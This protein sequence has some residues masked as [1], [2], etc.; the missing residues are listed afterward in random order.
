MPVRLLSSSMI[1]MRSGIA[2]RRVTS[3]CERFR[4]AVYRSPGIPGNRLPLPLPERGNRRY[5]SPAK[6]LRQ[7]RELP[8]LLG[9]Q[10]IGRVGNRVEQSLRCRIRELELGLPYLLQRFAVHARLLERL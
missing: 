3:A 10:Y 7:F 2:A 9:G 8:A 6:T 4:Q 5:A 1:K